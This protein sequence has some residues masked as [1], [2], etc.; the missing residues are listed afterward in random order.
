MQ[1]V[2]E[3]QRTLNSSRSPNSSCAWHEPHSFTHC[4]A[5]A[6]KCSP[7]ALSNRAPVFGDV[8][9]DDDNCLKKL[10]FH[11]AS[12]LQSSSSLHCTQQATT[13][14]TIVI[15]S[16]SPK[17]SPLATSLHGHL[18]RP[19]LGTDK[20]PTRLQERKA[21]ARNYCSVLHA[22]IA[23]NNCTRNH[24]FIGDAVNYKSLCKVDLDGNVAIL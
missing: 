3:T 11:V 6:V 4:T 23:R 16:P 21:E 22:K 9:V 20:C 24:V 7:T 8:V 13:T 17:P 14:A 12:A 2:R 1:C 19:V 18:R 5:A 15:I 10:F